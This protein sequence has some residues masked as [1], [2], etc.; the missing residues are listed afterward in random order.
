M[1][2]C[3]DADVNTQ[4][5]YKLTAKLGIQTRDLR[6]LD[7]KFTGTYPSCILCRDKSIVVNLEHIKAIITT[8]FML[9]VNPEET[10]KFVATL[11]ERLATPGGVGK[12]MQDLQKAGAAPA[13]PRFDMDL[14]F[15]L[16]ALEICLDEVRVW[17]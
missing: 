15:E 14:P 12:S 2:I 10:M 11:K 17:S 3:H 5:K 13:I 8:K 6:L 1:H 16:R 7:P 9:V 4:D